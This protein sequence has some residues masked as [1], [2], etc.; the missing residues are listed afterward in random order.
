MIGYIDTKYYKK[1]KHIKKKQMSGASLARKIGMEK[2]SDLWSEFCPIF[3]PLFTFPFLMLGIM[4][5]I[6]YKVH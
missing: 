1:E 4:I 6:V 2:A 5:S 3:A